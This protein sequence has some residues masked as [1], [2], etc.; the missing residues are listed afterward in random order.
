MAPS[1]TCPSD[2]GQARWAQVSRRQLARP[3]ESLKS[4]QRWWKS[5]RGHDA[6]RGQAGAELGGE[7]EVLQVGREPRVRPQLARLPGLLGCVGLLLLLLL[8]RGW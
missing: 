3:A 8:L 4:T 5:S 1:T 6:P 7:P 2:R